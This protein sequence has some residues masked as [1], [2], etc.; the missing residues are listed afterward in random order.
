MRRSSSCGRLPMLFPLYFDDTFKILLSGCCNK[1]YSTL[2][3]PLLHCLLIYYT[4]DV[5]IC[6]ENGSWHTYAMH[7]VLPPEP[8]VTGNTTRPLHSST[9]FR[10]PATV[11]RKSTCKNLSSDRHRSKINPRTSLH[12]TP[13]LPLPLSG[14]VV[15]H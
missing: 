5:N 6:V 8:G 13:L 11:Y 15:F 3:T 14:K 1:D 4:C 12:A 9:S 2:F 10:K 7:S